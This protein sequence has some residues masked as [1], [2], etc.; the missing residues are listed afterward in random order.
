MR[1]SRGGDVLAPGD[2]RDPV[3]F[4]DARD[5]SEWTIRVCE[6]RTFGTFNATGPAHPPTMRQMLAGVGKAVGGDAHLVWVPEKFL[7]ANGVAAWSDMPVWA[8]G[9]GDT[10]GFHRRDIHRA[11]AAGL[12]FRP[13][14]TTAI[15]TLAWFKTLPVDRQSKLKAGLTPDRET[16]LLA[17]WKAE[18]AA[19]KARARP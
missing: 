16:A 19:A 5:L 6:Q 2:G 7:D 4:I 17:K 1:L 10:A 14:A 15:D 12:T 11:R 13:L 8:P 3:Q 18:A 9:H